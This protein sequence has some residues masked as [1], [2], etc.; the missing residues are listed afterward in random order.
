MKYPKKGKTKRHL[1]K[2]ESQTKKPGSFST[3]STSRSMMPKYTQSNTLFYILFN[4]SV[5]RITAIFSQS[6]FAFVTVL[7][8]SRSHRHFYGTSEI[9]NEL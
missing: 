6:L 4:F 5:K 1:S 2:K 7:C 3:P 9:L 8:I